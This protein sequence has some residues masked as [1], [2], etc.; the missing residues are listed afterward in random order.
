[1][2]YFNQELNDIGFK[3]YEVCE[4]LK[5]YIYNYW[6][7]EGEL[8]TPIQSKILSDGSV[9]FIINFANPYAITI[10]DDHQKQHSKVVLNGQT[11]YPS[12]LHFENELNAIGIRFKAGC[13]YGLFCEELVSFENKNIDFYDNAHWMFDSLYQELMCLN[14]NDEKILCIEMFLCKHLQKKKASNHKKTQDIIAYI[15]RF[16]GDVII[17]DMCEHFNVSS[18]TLERIFKKEVGLNA[19][20]FTRI[21]RLRHVRENLSNLEVDNFSILGQERGFFD[22]SHFIKEFK[23]FMFETPKS[24]FENKLKMAKKFNYKKY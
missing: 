10:N 8:S 9:G 21:I 4:E 22:Q 1:M 11:K 19:K 13:A 14:S 6:S 3:I 5:P 23:Y 15:N 12:I 2:G 18:R 20:L 17:E 24:Y 16:K 7:I